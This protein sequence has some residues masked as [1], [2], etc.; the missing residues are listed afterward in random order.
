MANKRKPAKQAARKQST[1]KKK[2]APK[3]RRGN[4]PPRHNIL[5]QGIGVVSSIAFTGTDYETQFLQ[6]AGVAAV[7]SS[8]G[9]YDH[10]RMATAVQGYNDDPNIGLIVS[11][12]GLG[13]AMEVLANATKPWIALI[14]AAPGTFPSSQLTYFRGA[15]SVESYPYNTQRLQYLTQ[16]KHIPLGNICLLFNPNSSCS[17]VETHD[18]PSAASPPIA[19]GTYG[20]NDTTAFPAAFNSIPLNVTVVVISGDP[21]FQ[22]RK[23]DLITAANAWLS[24]SATRQF[25]VYPCKEYKNGTTKPTAN[26]RICHGPSLKNAYNKLGQRAASVLAGGGGFNL[27]RQPIGNPDGT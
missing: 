5:A 9:D 11:V 10:H 16:T 8:D 23:D 1:A 24:G 4:K 20:S 7:Q 14:G 22:D 21:F 18:W 17:A 6:G 27:D 25:V 19:V 3:E 13:T 26:K 2:A 15:V 12:G